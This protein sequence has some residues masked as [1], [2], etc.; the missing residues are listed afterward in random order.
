VQGA[1]PALQRRR[2]DPMLMERS[3]NKVQGLSKLLLLERLRTPEA[4]FRCAIKRLTSQQR[5]GLLQDRV[6]H[7]PKPA[8]AVML[9]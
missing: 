2:I 5:L 7:H 6:C 4:R 9:G 3:W 8:F 1:V